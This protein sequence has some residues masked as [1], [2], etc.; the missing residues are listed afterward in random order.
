MK[1]KYLYSIYTV[2]YVIF[3]SIINVLRPDRVAVAITLVSI[4]PQSN[5]STL[6]SIISGKFLKKKQKQIGL[7]FIPVKIIHSLQDK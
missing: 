6:N 4:L 7:C 1:Y 2:A 5:K 3:I